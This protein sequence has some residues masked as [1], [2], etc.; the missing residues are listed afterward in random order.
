MSELGCGRLSEVEE[1]VIW[2]E[3]KVA[4]PDIITIC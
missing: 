2:I 1:Q 3:M 4:Y